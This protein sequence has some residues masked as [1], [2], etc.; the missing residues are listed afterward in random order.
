MHPELESAFSLAGRTAVITGAANG[1][2]RQAALTFAMAGANV[3]IADV[4]DD[5]TESARLASELG[6][7]VTART[8]DVR[9]KSDVDALAQL[10]IDTYGGID[11]WANVAGIIRYSKER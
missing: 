9:E 10:A 2:G 3:V 4:K 5:L 1:I 6:G 7:R 11:V 8:T